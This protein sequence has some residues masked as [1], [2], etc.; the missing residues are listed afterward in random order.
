M[1]PRLVVLLILSAAE[2]L[3]KITS[4]RF[5]NCSQCAQGRATGR[6]Q[7]RVKLGVTPRRV[8][9][10]WWQCHT[11]VPTEITVCPFPCTIAQC[12]PAGHERSNALIG[13][14]AHCGT[15]LSRHLKSASW[16][17]SG[18]RFA[19]P[20]VDAPQP[21]LN[22]FR[23]STLPSVTISLGDDIFI[24]LR[25][26]ASLQMKVPEQQVFIQSCLVHQFASFQML[27]ASTDGLNHGH[28]V[29][30]R[31]AGNMPLCVAYAVHG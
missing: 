29:A 14:G 12:V 8:S 10:R 23:K 18:G 20:I 25:T 22:S 21:C 31:Y 5:V 11:A 19:S 1:L 24:T 15:R 4:L 17:L 16:P 13:E 7:E 26:I 9:T 3:A 2:R 30:H 6:W 28:C 27:R